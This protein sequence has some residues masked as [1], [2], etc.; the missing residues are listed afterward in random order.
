MKIF[1]KEVAASIKK[2]GLVSN[3]KSAISVVNGGKNLSTM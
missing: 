1:V 3:G 2:S